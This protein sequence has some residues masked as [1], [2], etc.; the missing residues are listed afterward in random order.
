[1]ISVISEIMAFLSNTQLQRFKTD[2]CP[3]FLRG[4]S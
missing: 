4:Q 1:M 2:F 3:Y